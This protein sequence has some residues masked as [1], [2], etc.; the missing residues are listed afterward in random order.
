MNVEYLN[1][2]SE[3]LEYSKTKT[4]IQQDQTKQSTKHPRQTCGK[5]FFTAQSLSAHE[6][7][8]TGEKTFSCDICK[9]TFSQSIHLS[10]H[11][12]NHAGGKP[13]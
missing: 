6:R 3:I 9:K 2:T 1:S 10:F 7:I 4:N 5:T 8:H 11:K 12:R 13:Y